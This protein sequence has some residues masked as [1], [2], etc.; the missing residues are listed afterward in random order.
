MG[1]FALRSLAG[2]VD[3]AEAAPEAAAT[4]SE[5]AAPK[6]RKLDAQL[7]LVDVVSAA[8]GDNSS[9]PAKAARTSSGKA[10]CIDSAAFQDPAAKF[11]VMAQRMSQHGTDGEQVKP[12]T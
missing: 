10:V 6:K 4:A 11:A 7:Q 1:T 2:N 5:A 12:I 9:K 3:W 8:A